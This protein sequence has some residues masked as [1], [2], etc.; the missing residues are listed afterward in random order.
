[1][2]KEYRKQ[3]NIKKS[4]NQFLT[5]FRIVYI[6]NCGTY[7]CEDSTYAL[8]SKKKKSILDEAM[9][10]L[11]SQKI[12]FVKVTRIITHSNGELIYVDN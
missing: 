9:N 2:A 7:S 11:K 12:K 3:Y 4:K 8:L 5:R 6:V 10:Y 1:M